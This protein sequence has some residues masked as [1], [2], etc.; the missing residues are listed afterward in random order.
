MTLVAACRDVLRVVSAQEGSDYDDDLAPVIEEADDLSQ[1][2]GEVW[3]DE[4]PAYRGIEHNHQYV[5]HD[6]G[7]VSDDGVH[8]NQAECL[9]LLLQPWLAKFRGPSKQGLEQAARTRLPPVTEP[10]W[11]TAPRSRRLHRRQRIP[12]VPPVYR[13]AFSNRHQLSR[14]GSR[15]VSPD[16]M[17]RVLTV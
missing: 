15:T 3:T 2:L 7:Y 9:W 10:Y 11:G 4:L 12:L 6:E 16:D 13:R 14:L 5:V 1:E 17:R 8:M